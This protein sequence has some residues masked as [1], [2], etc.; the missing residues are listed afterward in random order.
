[1]QEYIVSITIKEVE[2]MKK[3]IDIRLKVKKG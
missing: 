2:K 1:M 3:N